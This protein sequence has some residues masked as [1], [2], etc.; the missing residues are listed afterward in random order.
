MLVSVVPCIVNSGMFLDGGANILVHVVVYQIEPLVL[1]QQRDILGTQILQLGPFQKKKLTHLT[2][3]R[4]LFFLASLAG[5]SLYYE[6]GSVRT[7]GGGY[8]C[9]S[10][11]VGDSV[12][13][14]GGVRIV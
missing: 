4:D 9:V 14:T 3:V 6:G 13:A 1:R 10:M 8:N 7:T 12:R 5:P 11:G 2:V